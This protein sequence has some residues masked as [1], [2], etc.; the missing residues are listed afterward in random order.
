MLRTT[1]ALLAAG[2]LSGCAAS[3]SFN[4]TASNSNQ[5]Q[6]ELAA[7][8]GHVSYPTTMPESHD[9][10]AAAMVTSDQK[11]LKIYNFGRDPISN[12]DVWVNGAFVYHVDNVAPQSSVAIPTSE[13]FNSVGASLA[14]QAAPITRVQLKTDNALYTLWGPAAL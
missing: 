13:L 12:A 2:A 14:S 10:K 3:A 8:A 6:T 9:L 5:S 11:L 7:Y 4:P 1:L